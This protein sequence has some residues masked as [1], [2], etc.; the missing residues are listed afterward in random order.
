M[1]EEARESRYG[2]LDINALTNA[3]NVLWPVFALFFIGMASTVL[4]FI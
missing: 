4:W 3:Y 2:E 1:T